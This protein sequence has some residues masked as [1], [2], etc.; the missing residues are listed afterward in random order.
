MQWSFGNR[1]SG[2][3]KVKTLTESIESTAP[4][5]TGIQY[6]S[7]KKLLVEGIELS[8]PSANKPY[9]KRDA[10][11]AARFAE[12][13]ALT[14]AEKGP[15]EEDEIE[16][17]RRL[18]GGG[19]AEDLEAPAGAAG[20]SEIEE[21]AEAKLGEGMMGGMGINFKKQFAMQESVKDDMLNSDEAPKKLA[22]KQFDKM[23]EHMNKIF[24][25]ALPGSAKFGVDKNPYSDK[26]KLDDTTKVKA[27]TK[28]AKLNLTG[29]GRLFESAGY[30]MPGTFK[31]KKF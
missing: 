24:N 7:E 25:K 13:S 3:E 19:S 1:N 10:V 26:P 4:S 17:R 6:S 22:T 14:E 23:T 8:L 20:N 18:I 30:H 16:Q 21:T 31:I 28:K 5:K 29:T 2:L 15:K 11:K 9:V 27:E 12:L